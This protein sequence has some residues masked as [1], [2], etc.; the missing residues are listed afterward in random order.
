[1]IRKAFFDINSDQKLLA[2]YQ[3]EC[4]GV[5]VYSLPRLFCGKELINA[6][7]QVGNPIKIDII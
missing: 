5:N 3:I 2:E 7:N 1:M 4:Y 6:K